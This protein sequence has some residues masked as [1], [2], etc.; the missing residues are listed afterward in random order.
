MKGTT[1]FFVSLV[2]LAQS[3]LDRPRLGVMLDSSGAARPV[4]GVAGSVTLGDPSEGA[5]VSCACS[6]T[7]CLFKTDTSLNGVPAPP[8]PA[9]FAFD[10]DAAYVYFPSTHQLARWQAGFRW[11]DAGLPQGDIIALRVIDGRFDFAVRRGARTYVVNHSAH[12]QAIV[13]TAGPVMLI[14]GGILYATSTE[15]ALRRAD[16][17]ERRFPL[18]NASSISAM[19]SGY[20][21]I[22]AGRSSYALR[23]DAGRERL[24]QLPE[25]R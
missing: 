21:Q 15:I 6:G 24:F 2:A 7:F 12:T 19:G 25:V 8:G 23:L 16:G 13:D 14:E 11:L 4:F 17:S 5:I 9:L 1:I 18:A 10:G 3:G 20:A 22:R